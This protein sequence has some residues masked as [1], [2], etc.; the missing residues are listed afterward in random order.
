M[1]KYF[2]SPRCPRC[3]RIQQWNRT[4]WQMGNMLGMMRRQ[5]TKEN[6]PLP[7][8][9][10]TQTTGT[11][12]IMN[13][14]L[15]GGR[16]PFQGKVHG[17]TLVTPT[18][19]LQKNPPNPYHHLLRL[20]GKLKSQ[21]SHQPCHPGRTPCHHSNKRLRRPRDRLQSPKHISSRISTGMMRRSKIHVN[22]PY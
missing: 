12:S 13:Q 4:S 10:P 9:S 2:Q 17:R 7:C 3:R 16:S 21:N 14:C 18:M 22:L 11:S 8:T 15:R 20:H 1:T 5:R 19:S 6:N